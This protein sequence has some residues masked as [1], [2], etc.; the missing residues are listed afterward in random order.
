MIL[1]VSD[2]RL[3]T[4]SNVEQPPLP[5]VLSQSEMDTVE[6]Q[7]K[8]WNKMVKGQE[9]IFTLSLGGVCDVLQRDKD[10]SN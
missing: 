1:L 4:V 9:I 5:P 8:Q 3:H 2:R 6:D 7:R 10:K